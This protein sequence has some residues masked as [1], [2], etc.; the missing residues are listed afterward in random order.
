MFLI[1]RLPKI[2]F[3]LFIVRPVVYLMLGLNVQHRELLPTRG[4]A[5]LAANHNSH[6]DTLTLMA[7]YP[8]SALH[9]IRPVAAA[10]YFLRNRFTSWLSLNLIG[11]IPLDRQGGVDKDKVFAQCQQALRDE[12][13]LLLFPEGS[14][15]DPEQLQPLRKGIYHLA[16][17]HAGTS[18]TPIAL[19]GLGRALPRGG[20]MIVPFNCDVVIGP[21]LTPDDDS[22]AFMSA[23]QLTLESQLANCITRR[24]FSD[25]LE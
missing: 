19:H 18:V 12:Q 15:G 4:P 16:R 13:I 22:D 21:A 24:E 9:R 10:D 17:S 20:S 11:I 23:L 3:F 7:L 14:R 6:L 1:K 2:A 8:L 5:I 25:R